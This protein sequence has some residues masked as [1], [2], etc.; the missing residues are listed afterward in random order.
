MVV[1]KKANLKANVLLGSQ[2]FAPIR[3]DRVK[4]NCN[5][6]Y[7]TIHVA[8]VNFATEMIIWIGNQSGEVFNIYT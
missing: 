2:A 3:S 8:E 4:E 5:L 7:N 1:I 6:V